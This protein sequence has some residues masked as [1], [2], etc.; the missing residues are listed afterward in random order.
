ME[1]SAGGSN[2]RGV[3]DSDRIAAAIERYLREGKHEPDHPEW[4]GNFLDRCR[5]GHEELVAALVDEVR[6][7]ATGRE[8][9]PVPQDLDVVSWTRRKMTPMV[10]A[11]FLRSSVNPS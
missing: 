6:T 7:R 9:A 11:C 3:T 8:H 10:K 2:V 4:P 1:R 5:R